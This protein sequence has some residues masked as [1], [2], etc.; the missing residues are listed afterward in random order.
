MFTDLT[1]MYFIINFISV[2]IFI[3]NTK[4]LLISS[5]LLID[6]IKINVK[7]VKSNMLWKAIG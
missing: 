6:K 2:K 1:A 3:L 4:F 7:F 5:L